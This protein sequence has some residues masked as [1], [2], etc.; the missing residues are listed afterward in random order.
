MGERV[1]GTINGDF[2]DTSTGAPLGI[3]ISGGEL[4]S[5][6]G[7]YYAVGFRADGSA[8][9]GDPQLD[10]AVSR[11]S[12][13]E[14]ME[15]SSMNK[16]RPEGGGIALLTDDYRTDHTTGV[17]TQ[18]VSALCTVLGGRP[19]I[20]GT[21]DLRVDRVAEGAQ[22]VAMGEDQ[23]VLTV[24]DAGSAGALAFL[25]ELTAG[26]SLRL[27][28]SAAPGWETVTEAMGALHLL[29]KDGAPQTGFEASYAPPHRHRPA[30]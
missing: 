8:V 10:M 2:Y 24:A 26:E 15:I 1:V 5:G 25:R 28:F 9:M 19:A 30:I 22:P 29:V 12:G 7:G 6:I 17:S 13:G 23:V 16:G 4:I 21:L 20:G 3:L 27:T 14:S 11:L 18:G